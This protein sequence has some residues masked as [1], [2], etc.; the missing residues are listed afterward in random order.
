MLDVVER[1]RR[2]LTKTEPSPEAYLAVLKKLGLKS[3]VARLKLG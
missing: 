2:N 3:F 1:A